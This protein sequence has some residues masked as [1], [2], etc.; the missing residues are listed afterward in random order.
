[1][2]VFIKCSIT[3]VFLFLS[4]SVYAKTSVWVAEKEGKKIIL[5]GSVHLLKPSQFPLPKAYIKALDTSERIVFELNM[6][7]V[8][9]KAVGRKLTQS[10]K[11]S[12][13][14][15]LQGT[16]Q[17]K[18]W[19]ALK[20]TINDDN[21]LYSLDSFDAAFISFS[22]PILIWQGQ[23]YR[24]GIDEFLYKRAKQKGKIIEGLE[25]TD[26]QL[27]A[28]KLLKQIEP[29]ELIMKMLEELA[30][31]KLSLDRLIADLYRGDQTV[32]N[33]RIDA[34]NEE[35]KIFYESLLVNRNQAWLVKIDKL[36][37]DGTPTMIV[38]GA[39]H[40]AGRDGL[41]EQLKK[42]GYKINYY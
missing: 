3:F 30:D 22:L 16:L 37:E 40:L 2:R 17:P 10:F 25:T 27:S 8:E 33:E 6:D 11:L 21:T 12:N 31:P 20:K 4:L 35:N 18:T 42:R 23:G 24:A 5:A 28:L 13:R 7:K 15:S 29:D 38:V 39:M 36:M 1:M 9:P 19:E 32:L 14:I 26:E 41:L 34:Y